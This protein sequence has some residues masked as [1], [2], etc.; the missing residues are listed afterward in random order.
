MQIAIKKSLDEYLNPILDFCK[1][2]SK[3]KNH[4]YFI[5]FR[6]WN[7]DEEKKCKRV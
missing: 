1:I 6:I 5:N 2:C 7:L 3:Y 4:E